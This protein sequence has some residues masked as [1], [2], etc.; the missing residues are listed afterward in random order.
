MV[1]NPPRR[2]RWRVGWQRL[3]CALGARRGHAAANAGVATAG[4]LQSE[5]A[6][7]ANRAA[8][9]LHAHI[10]GDGSF[11]YRID[12]VSGRE[13]LRRYN[14]LRH[15]GSVLALVQHARA[16]GL[17]EGDGPRLMRSARFLV[18]HCIRAPQS[19]PQSAPH[20]LAVWSDPALT[21]GRRTHAVAKL[22]GNGLVLAALVEFRALQRETMVCAEGRTQTPDAALCGDV[23]TLDGLRALGEFVCF[24]QRAD[25]SFQSLFSDGA[26]ARE[27]AW[28]SLYYPGQAALGLLMLHD[29]DADPRWLAAAVRALRYLALSRHG[30]SAPADHWALIATARVF[31]LPAATM[32][33]SV[34][35]ALISH[36]EAVCATILS[37][38]CVV[39]RGRC[40]A[41]WFGP[42]PRVAPTATRLEGLL[43]ASA[44]PLS[45]EQMPRMR[46]A[47]DAGLRFVLDSQLQSGPA[48]GGFTRTHLSCARANDRRATEVRID[49][50]QHALAALRARLQQP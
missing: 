49:Y 41:G 35:A 3:M 50:V 5:L 39:R 42:E 37:E 46:A 7:A 34:R 33:A 19:A 32:P 16:T 13:D 2:L 31:A 18:D 14:V 36:A 12:A 28:T 24:M 43:A 9:Y 22:G 21:G 29:I 40:A 10:R 15:A 44:L 1:M 4:L 11:V 38:Q 25:G 17:G 47:C 48:A 26:Y 23:L 45:A 20:M 27:H 30:Q 6:A 8:R